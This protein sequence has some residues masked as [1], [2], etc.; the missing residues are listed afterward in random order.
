MA[1]KKDKSTKAGL[2]R[3]LT[4]APEAREDGQT[5][6]PVEGRFR[7]FGK[8]FG[9]NNGQLML[10]NALF[11]VTLLPLLAVFVILSVL[12]AEGLSYKIN[13]IIDKPYFLSGVGIGM[14][15]ASDVISAKIQMLSVY[16]WTFLFAGIGVFIA[17]IGLAGMMHL[18]VKFIWNDSFVTKKDSYGNDVPRVIVEFFR[19]I[20]KYWW[21]TLIATL[22]A[23]ILIGGTGNIFVY[24]LGKF[25]AGTAGAG[26]W[27]LIILTSIVAVV[28]LVFVLLLLPTVVMY[29]INFAQ[30]MKNAIIITLQMPLQNLFLLIAVAV[31]FVIAAVT[32]GFISIIFVA[33]L[34]VFGCPVYG[35]TVSNY[36]QYFSEKIITPVYIAQ[37]QKA[38]KN[39]KK[40]K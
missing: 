38:K 13:G 5:S 29:D 7:Y 27:I 39:T 19:G 17:G 36:M 20:K 1:T 37:T 31:P 14:S 21:Q 33:L 23:G 40:R 4:F 11:I 35:L 28:G 2:F 22:I 30:K 3:F 25:W 26:E 10:A 16:S 8:T 9:K 24:F 12:G 34:L 18:C 32:S 6:S 15:N